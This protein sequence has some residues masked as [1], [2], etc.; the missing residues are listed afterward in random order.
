M[1]EFT[2]ILYYYKVV[3]EIHYRRTT[4]TIVFILKCV[5][6]KSMYRLTQFHYWPPV[7]GVCST[8]QDHCVNIIDCAILILSGLIWIWFIF[9]I[10]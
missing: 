7:Y 4:V 9:K 8:G 6:L 10:I 1:Y 3:A 5:T 2:V